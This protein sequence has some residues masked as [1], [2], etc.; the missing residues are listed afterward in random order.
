MAADLAGFFHQADGHLGGQLLQPDRRRQA[1]RAAAHD[2]D[3]ELHR[4]ALG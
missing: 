4:F 3:I 2:H 1:G